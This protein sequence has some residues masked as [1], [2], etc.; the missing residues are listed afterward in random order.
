MMILRAEKEREDKAQNACILGFGLVKQICIRS[1]H[2]FCSDR[3][4][5]CADRLS[6]SRDNLPEISGCIFNLKI[7]T[8]KF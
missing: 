5:I 1:E 4:H 6:R 3:L 8:K 2:S 7:D